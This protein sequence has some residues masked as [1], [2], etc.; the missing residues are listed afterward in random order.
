MHVM[1]QQCATNLSDRTEVRE[2]LLVIF[3]RQAVAAADAIDLR[4]RL[5]LDVR[6]TRDVGREPLLD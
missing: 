2:V 6:A 1:A 3:I 5:L 4:L